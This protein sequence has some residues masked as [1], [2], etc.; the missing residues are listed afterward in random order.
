MADCSLTMHVMALGSGEKFDWNLLGV[1][2]C[3]DAVMDRHRFCGSGVPFVQGHLVLA[4][5]GILSAGRRNLDRFVLVDFADVTLAVISSRG[6][7]DDSCCGS[8]RDGGCVG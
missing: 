3:A 8:D 5:F 4:G 6:A 1:V 2:R 7:M